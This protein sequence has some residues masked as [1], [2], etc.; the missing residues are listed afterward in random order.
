MLL[1]PLAAQSLHLV[2]KGLA[3]ILGSLGTDIAARSEH[4]AVLADL[5]QRGGFT[6]A[7]DVFVLARVLLTPP[8]MI[9]SSNL[10][11]IGIGQF[12]PRAV[13]QLAQFT[14]VDE[15]HFAA[16]V[17]QGRAA[18]LAVGF[19]AGEEPQTGRDLRGVEQLPRQGL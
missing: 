19:I 14:G 4:M 11:D 7:G 10:L 5:V 8:R 15:Q 16:P 1:A 2:D 3:V 9:G 13:D 18:A 6:E 17:A 12:A